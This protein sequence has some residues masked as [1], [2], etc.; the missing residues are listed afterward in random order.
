[1]STS[2]PPL[3]EHATRDL[4]RFGASLRYEDIPR[5]AIER[6]KSSV[7]DSLG[8][9]LYGATLPWTRKVAQLADGEGARGVASC[10]GMGRKSSV[11]LA[12]LVNSTSGHAFELDDIH[13]ESIVHAG[14]IATPVALAFAEEQGGASGRDVL[15]AMVAG[16]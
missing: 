10:I 2:K 1:M 4:A 14:S 13:K 8:C 9:C 3:L 12:V 7:L 16:Y 5:E 6:M 11:A 15:T